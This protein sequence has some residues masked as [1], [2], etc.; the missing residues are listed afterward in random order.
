MRYIE[1]LQKYKVDYGE[2]M[3]G[4]ESMNMVCSMTIHSSKGLEFPIVI[5]AR[6]GKKFNLMDTRKS[7]VAHPKFGVGIN[8]VNSKVRV[9]NPTLLKNVH[10]QMK[11]KQCLIIVWVQEVRA[12]RV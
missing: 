9:K 5:V 4:D 2:A 3:L 6:C 11:V 10:I 1:Q 7:V 8:Y 12:W